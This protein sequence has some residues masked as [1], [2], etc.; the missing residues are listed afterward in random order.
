MC[1]LPRT[2]GCLKVVR[3]HVDKIDRRSFCSSN[4]PIVENLEIGSV[5]SKPSK[6]TRRYASYH[7]QRGSLLWSSHALHL[8]IQVW[9]YS[10]MTSFIFGTV[11]RRPSLP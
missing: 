4:V 2:C 3:N 7:G 1:N 9:G 10:L 6:T 5:S 8:H 11:E